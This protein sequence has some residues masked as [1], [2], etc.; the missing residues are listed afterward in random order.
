M[1][2]NEPTVIVKISKSELNIIVES[3]KKFVKY[4]NSVPKIKE[5]VNSLHKDFIKIKN[6]LEKYEKEDEKEREV[7]YEKGKECEVCD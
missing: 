3:L 4:T 1:K 5:M 2:K 6:D 7:T